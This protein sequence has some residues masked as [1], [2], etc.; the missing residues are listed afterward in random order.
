[1]NYDAVL[2]S[3]TDTWLPFFGFLGVIIALFFIYSIVKRK[4]K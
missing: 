1:M 2:Q 3:I 4:Q